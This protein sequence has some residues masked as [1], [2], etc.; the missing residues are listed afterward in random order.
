[1]TRKQIGWA[2]LILG[3]TLQ[4][5]EGLAQADATLNGLQFNQTAIGSI[6]A[7][8]EKVLPISMG[9]TVLL[10]GAALVWVVPWVEKA[11]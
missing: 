10:V 2:F 5:A 3:G 8:V 4:V 6:V 7:P 1:M 9:W 11:S